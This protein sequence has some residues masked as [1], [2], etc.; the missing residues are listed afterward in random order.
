MWRERILLRSRILM[1]KWPP[2]PTW[3]AYLTLPKLPSPRVRPISYLPS[4]DARV[5]SASACAPFTIH[6]RTRVERLGVAAG[7][8]L[9]P[10]N[11]PLCVSLA[12]A[13]AEEALGWNRNGRRT[14]EAGRQVQGE[15]GGGRVLIASS[16]CSSSSLSRVSTLLPVLSLVLQAEAEAAFRLLA[17]S[18]ALRRLSLRFREM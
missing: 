11:L 17:C 1:A 16:S 5:H 12:G 6:K 14:D 8:L 4:S 15:G 2:V 3:R 7:L 18:D 13:A 9:D 10:F